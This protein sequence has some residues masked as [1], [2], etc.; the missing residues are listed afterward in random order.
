MDTIISNGGSYEVS[1]KLS[2]FLRSL[3]IADYQSESYHQHQNKAQ[4]DYPS[5]VH[6]GDEIF[7]FRAITAHQG[8]PQQDDPTTRAANTN[9]ILS[10]SKILLVLYS[11]E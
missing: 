10:K 11:C 9:R 2:D 5:Q 1:K 3:L 4:Q 6:S 8:L 7:K